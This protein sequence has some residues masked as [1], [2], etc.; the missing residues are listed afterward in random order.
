MLQ[1]LNIKVS[2]DGFSHDLIFGMFFFIMCGEKDN[3][4]IYSVILLFKEINKYP[5]LD[6]KQ[7]IQYKNLFPA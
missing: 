7:L 3:F 5:K 1:G 2:N 4:F 6:S